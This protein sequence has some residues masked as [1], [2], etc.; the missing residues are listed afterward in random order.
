VGTLNKPTDTGRGAGHV[1]NRSNGGDSVRLDDPAYAEKLATKLGQLAWF[2]YRIRS[3]RAEDIVQT[4]FATFLAVR[5]RYEKVA[6]HP[7]ILIGI[8]RK[9]CL[10]H[11]D[12][13]V[14]DQRKLDQYCRSAAA[15]RENPWIRPRRAGE[16]HSVIDELIRREERTQIKN[17]IDSLRPSS[18]E[19][20]SKMVEDGMG[21][22]ELVEHL[23][24]NKNTVDSRLHVTR[25][26][27]RKILKSHQ[28]TA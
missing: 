19:L 8:F 27:L 18:R 14:R 26:E 5:H 10:E 25:R 15:A 1:A 24:L 4:S 6:D 22:K 12:R 17:A 21:R 16:S 3:Q 11:I 23:G 28:I 13:S 9:K 20:V 7:A 2:R